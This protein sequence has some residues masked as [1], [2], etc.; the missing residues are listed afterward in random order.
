[1]ANYEYIKKRLDRLGQE[2]GTWEVNWQEILDYVMPRKADVVTL[3]TRGEKRTEVLFDS[4]AITA[5][6][7]L[8]ASLQ[9][10]L[11][12]PSLPWFSIKL[13]D[14]ELNEDRDVQLWLEDTARR[15][16]DTFNETNFNTEVHEMYLDLCSIGTA[17]LF[18]EEGSKG[19]DTDGIHFN[20]L[21]IAEYYIQESIDGKVDT[22]YR[23]YKLTARQAV[24]EFGFDNVGEKI[25]TASKERPDHKF[26][27]IH[28]VEPTADY[29]RSTGKSATKL[30]FHSCHVC[31]EDKMVVRTGGYNEFPYLVPRWSKATGEIFGRSPSF[32][33]LPDI[34]TLNKAVEI[35]LKAW[36]KAIDPPLLVQD[37]GVIGRVRMT[38]AGITVIR[39]DGAV[40]PLQIGTNWQITDLKENQLRTAI[41]QAYYSDQLQLQEGPQMTA[42]EVQVRYELMQRLLGP[43]LGRFQSEFLNPLI[44]RVFGI[45][46]RAGALMKEPDIIQGTKIDVEYLGP[47][48]RSQRMEESV[49]IERLYSLAMNIAQI[50][51]AIMDNIDHDE[52]VRLRGKL[53]GVPKTVLRG[54]DD[55]DNMRTMRAE[56]AQMA[57]MA[58]EQQALGKAQK[59]QA[60]AAKILADPNVSGGLEDTVNEM[61][62]ENIANEYGQGS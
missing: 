34:K 26:N 44:E 37:D 33:A 60:Q 22:L 6:N 47:L 54:K 16:Y 50:D 55:V 3:R 9:G 30:K 27:F 57:Q 17:A 14:E 19:F 11:T 15:M 35:G 45:M 48:A 46:Y 13:R 10:T 38:P 53:L 20:C 42:T 28:A 7:L 39:N 24:Q 31:E 4:T 8:A 62:M 32:N 18:V 49:A 58:Q 12:S 59:D 29:E 23:K 21:H 36:A 2:R 56:Q 1:M 43:T 52:A 25:Q 51:P 5:N 61:G 40:K 41:R